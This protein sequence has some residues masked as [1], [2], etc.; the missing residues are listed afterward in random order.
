MTRTNYKEQLEWF[1]NSIK[2]K[3]VTGYIKK[4]KAVIEQRQITRIQALETNSSNNNKSTP[5]YQPPNFTYSTSFNKSGQKVYNSPEPT[6]LGRINSGSKREAEDTEY[7][8]LT[9]SQTK[10]PKLDS[11]QNSSFSEDVMTIEQGPIDFDDDF[12]L[13]EEEIPPEENEQLIT[14]ELKTLEDKRNQISNLILDGMGS[15]S[16]T[17]QD[18]LMK[19]RRELVQKIEQLEQKLSTYKNNLPINNS[20]NTLATTTEPVLFTEQTENQVTSPFFRNPVKPHIPLIPIINTPI[21]APVT[22]PTF[23]WSRDVKKALIQNFKLSEFRPNQL[24]AIN[25]TLNGD[26]VFVLMPTGGGKSLCYQLP[27]II[28]RYKTQGVTFVVSPLLSLMQ[29][30]VEQLVKGRGIAA[31]MLNSSVTAEQKKWIYNNLYQDTPTLQLLYITPEL[32]SKSDQLRNV[33][34]SLHRRNKLARFVIDEAHCVSQW[35]HDFRPDYKQLGSL[36]NIYPNVPIM[37]LTATANDAVQK[38]VIHNLSM[39]NCKILKQSF[40]RRNLVYEIIERKG[41]RNHLVDINEFIKQHYTESGIIYCISRKDCEQVAEALRTTYGVSTKHYHGKM[42]SSERSEVQSEWQTGKIRV[43]V[44]T[45]AFGMGIDKPDVR[46]VVHFS[47]PSS[48]EGYYQETGRAGRDGLPAICRLYYSFSDMRTHNFL[49]D[50]GEGSWQQ[51]QRQRDNLNTMMRYCDNKADCRRKQILSYFGER[52]NPVHCQKMCDNCVANQHSTSFL[53]NMSTEAQQMARLLQQI[54][55]DRITLSQLGDVFRGSKLK[56][57]IEHQ[58]DQ[59]QG[60]GAGKSISKIDVDRLLKAMVADDIIAVKSECNSAG[61]PVSFVVTSS[62]F[63]SL[64]RGNHTV[65]LSF[66]SNGNSPARTNSTSRSYTATFVASSTLTYN[67][68]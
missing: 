39:K 53:K 36:R 63:E 62:K 57:I 41:K 4:Y 25:T 54:H 45:I 27:A 64:L 66:S 55:P 68:S 60:Y 34:D 29:D 65:L 43:I 6:G 44:A 67:R 11:K 22:E 18:A 14:A 42:T 9:D 1:N 26:D 37:A 10:R 49:I 48:L 19:E 59:L 16:K 46:Y 38:D 23:P 13:V 2:P 32:M 47:M 24:E 33:M 28:Q 35:G 52:F 17:E 7:I 15:L 51:K 50:Q 5:E 30:Q 61:F 58:Y 31:G 21:P 40:N 56:R 3:I 12:G 20:S 8:D